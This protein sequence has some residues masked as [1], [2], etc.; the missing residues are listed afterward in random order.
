MERRPVA[1]PLAVLP[2]RKWA[3]AAPPSAVLK[4][5]KPAAPGNRKSNRFKRNATTSEPKESQ[6]KGDSNT[7]AEAPA[8]TS[9]HKMTI[10][11]AREI[12]IPKIQPPRIPLRATPTKDAPPAKTPPSRSPNV[13]PNGTHN[14]MPPVTRDSRSTS[15]PSNDST[16]GTQAP[17]PKQNPNPLSPRPLPRTPTSPRDVKSPPPPVPTRKQASSPNL[18]LSPRPVKATPAS[19]SSQSSSPQRDLIAQELV[20]T[21]IDYNEH[22]RL[23]TDV[24]LSIYYC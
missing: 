6:K 22:L 2:P 9:K 16:N 24:S 19:S 12:H 23:I 13:P 7:L 17:P 18:P 4:F 15:Y 11:G 5:A 1:T 10:S 20:K 8:T 14:G 21:E 3:K